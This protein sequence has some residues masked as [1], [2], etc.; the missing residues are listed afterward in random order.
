LTAKRLFASFIAA[1]VLCACS[2]SAPRIS[3]TYES[4]LGFSFRL[5]PGWKM[6]GEEAKSKGGTLLSWQVKSL[7][8][9][10]ASWLAELPRSVVPEL[11]RWTQ[12][13]FGAY[14]D[15]VEHT[16]TVGGEPALIVTQTVT[17][18]K[19]PTPSI[20]RYWAVRHGEG[21]YLIRTVYPAGREQE[22]DPGVRALIA[23]WRFKPPTGP[24]PS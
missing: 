13:Y 24:L 5:P 22:E 11:Q 2:G 20:V 19:N 8:G 16:G 7:E 18:A 3:Q 1:A 21:L 10:Q 14:R 23:S 15:E 6:Y 17:V 12:H 9:A 4:E